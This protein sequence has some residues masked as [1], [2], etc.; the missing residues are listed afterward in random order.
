ME[1]EIK[2]TIK[3]IERSI[4]VVN[5]VVADGKGGKGCRVSM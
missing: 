1:E 3:K 4:F 2:K 5:K